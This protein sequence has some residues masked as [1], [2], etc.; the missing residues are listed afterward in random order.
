MADAV[1]S[2]RQRGLRREEKVRLALL[3]LP[4]FAL[5]LAISLVSTYLGEVTRRYTH[6]TA[7][8]GAILC[9]EGLMALWI[10]LL[11]GTWSDQLRTRIG[12]CLPFVLAGAIPAAVALAVLGFVGSLGA[13]AAVAALF[14]AFYFVAYEPYRAMYPDL[15]ER[16][17]AGRAQSSQAVAR[18]VGTGLALL[19]GGLLLSL[20]RPVPFVAGAVVVLVA[21]AAFVYLLVRRGMPEQPHE[22]AEGRARWPAACGAYWPRNP[23]SG[24]ISSP[25]PS[26]RWRWPH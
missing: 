19:G 15:L 10:P 7:V 25:T 26:G 14:F 2:R 13:V 11:A 20:G 23:R 3:A 22:D 16:E 4:T 5:A 8:I 1:R 9:A 17:V 24:H 12:G 18:G 21:I 6:Q